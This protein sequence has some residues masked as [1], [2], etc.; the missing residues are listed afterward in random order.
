MKNFIPDIRAGILYSLMITASLL[1]SCHSHAPDKSNSDFRP[2]SLFAPEYAQLFRTG[3]SG[4]FPAAHIMD[5]WDS[6]KIL[7]RLA[8]VPRGISLQSIPKGYSPVY[9]P[10]RS[11]ATTS[12]TLI[13]HL[14]DLGCLKVL[15]GVSD[16][17]FIF[18]SFVRKRIEKGLVTEIATGEKIHFEALIENDPDAAVFSLFPGQDNSRLQEV[19]IEMIPFADYLEQDPLARAEWIRFTGWLLGKDRLADSLF[20]ITAQRYNTLRKL[21]DS[22]GTRL[23]I[24][25]GWMTGGVWY[26]SGGRSYMARFYQ[27]AGLLYVFSGLPESGSKASGFEEVYSKASDAEVWRLIVSDRKGFSRKDILVSDSRYALFKA[28]RDGKILVCNAS[29][30]PYYEE[31]VARPDRILSD[32]IHGVYPGLLPGYQPYY[33]QTLP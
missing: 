20:R 27:D 24:F 9:V 29:L 25:D 3:Y 10:L 19:G 5:P 15:T 23:R 4:S 16:T 21:A 11:V 28:F 13:S 8:L 31:G 17:A 6:G 2:D 18:N 30:T 12:S 7:S 14:S 32:L 1:S 33:Y 26:I 22:A